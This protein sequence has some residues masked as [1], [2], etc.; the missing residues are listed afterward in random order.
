MMASDLKIYQASS[1]RSLKEVL[2]RLIFGS[3]ELLKYEIE[4]VQ[5]PTVSFTLPLFSNF[6][7]SRSCYIIFDLNTSW[8]L[9]SFF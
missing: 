6:E 8:N 1:P 2:M 9:E 5:N 7:A 4:E 3:P